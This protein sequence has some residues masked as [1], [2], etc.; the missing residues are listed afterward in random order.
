MREDRRRLVYDVLRRRA[1]KESIR[2]IARALDVHRKTVRKI[3]DEHSA[4]L[5]QGDDAL[6]RE[7][8][9]PRA[10]RASKLDPWVDRIDAL[11]ADPLRRG[12]TAW[13]IFEIITE[14]G[15]DGGYTIVRE[16]VA[17]V[18]PQG[19]KKAYDPVTLEPGK[20]AQFD[21]SPHTLP[22]CKI[23]VN[24]FSLKLHFSSHLFADFALDRTRPTLL[25]YFV[26]ALEDLGG[27]PYEIVFDSE[28]T[29]IDR[30]EMGR[31]IVNL[32]FLDFAAYYGFEVHVAPLSTGPL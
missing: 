25:R 27:V 9:K 26:A 4:R 32:A 13:R 19:A 31:P 28:K 30:W 16:R 12:I 14:E 3:L 8:P 23:A 2:G 1:R 11:L 18:R 24:T 5:E 7:L 22:G 10:P 6:A 21:W 17:K 15:Y 29:V 20:Q